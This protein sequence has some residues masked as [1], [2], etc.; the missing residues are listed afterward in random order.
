MRKIIICDI[1]HTISDATWRDHLSGEPSI[2]QGLA[3]ERQLSTWDA[4]NA[5]AIDDSPHLDVIEF[6][7][8]LSKHYSI[9]ALT[10]RPEKWR[11]VSMDWLIKHGVIADYLIMR[12]EGDFRPAPLLKTEIVKEVFKLSYIAFILDDREDVI[13]AFKAINVT[14]FHV[15]AKRV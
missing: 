5:A 9:C 3:D 7:N 14:S 6:L 15:H 10:A 4:Y 12:P 8:H 11:K 13:E 2:H 1:D